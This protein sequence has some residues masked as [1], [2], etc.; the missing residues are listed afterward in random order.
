MENIWK[1]LA[2]LFAGALASVLGTLLIQPPVP[3]YRVGAIVV[4]LIFL[5]LYGSDVISKMQKSHNIWSRKGNK[6]VAPKLGIL[7]DMEWKP[8]NNEISTCTNTTSKEWKEEIEKLARENKVRIKV[9]LINVGKS[10][11]PYAVVLN[12]YGG[13]YPERDLKNYGTL[14]KILTYVS[15]GGLFVNVT[16]VPGY[17]AYNP[18]LRRRLDATPPI[19][20]INIADGQ[21]SVLPVRPFEHTPFMKELGLQVLNTEQSS[22]HFRWKGEFEEEF[23]EIVQEIMEINVHRAVVVERNVVPILKPQMLNEK[24]ITPF[25]FVTHGDGMFL[26]SLVWLENTINAKMKKVLANKVIQL[27]GN[28]K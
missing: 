14:N 15:E 17:F 9:K 6:L 22:S 25:F 23:K 12:P 26:I 11:D 8:Q 7:N 16:D 13:V 27:M 24:R 3:I 10:F 28:K 18:L 4:V 2:L 20:G 1:S 5:I 21:I 19:Y